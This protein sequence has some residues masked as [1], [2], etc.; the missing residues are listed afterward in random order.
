M[1]GNW[2]KDGMRGF[3]KIIRVKGK[4]YEL[5]TSRCA[6]SYAGM[7]KVRREAIKYAG[8]DGK[9]Y[10]ITNTYCYAVYLPYS[11]ALRPKRR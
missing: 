5:W 2:K 3:D 8:R 6:S 7:Q 4:L 9:V 11:G 1:A 10:K